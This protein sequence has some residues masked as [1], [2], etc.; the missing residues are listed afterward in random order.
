MDVSAVNA[1]RVGACCTGHPAVRIMGSVQSTASSSFWFN[2]WSEPWRS[3]QS[4]SMPP[5]PQCSVLIKGAE[6][7]TVCINLKVMKLVV[8]DAALAV[9]GNTAYCTSARVSDLKVTSDMQLIGLI[10][11]NP[12]LE[13]V[14]GVRRFP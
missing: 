4:M 14:V 1:T 12:E 7:D 10:Q 13:D 5:G 2:T 6:H 9:N 11:T 8:E 3:V